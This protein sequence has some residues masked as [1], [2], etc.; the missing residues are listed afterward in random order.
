MVKKTRLDPNI[1]D[2]FKKASYEARLTPLF[3]GADA[4]VLKILRQAKKAHLIDGFKKIRSKET[5]LNPKSLY[6]IQAVHKDFR[7][8]HTLKGGVRTAPKSLTDYHMSVSLNS[9]NSVTIKFTTSQ[10]AWAAKKLSGFER[11]TAALNV[12]ENDDLETTSPQTAK[13]IK[14]IASFLSHHS[15][16]LNNKV[17]RQ[18]SS[19]EGGQVEVLAEEPPKPVDPPDVPHPRRPWIHRLWQRVKDGPQ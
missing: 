14:D 1:T 3:L 5:P 19:Q 4:L 16:I 9:D 10:F 2:I 13:F 12:V 7:Y 18:K 6:Y 15:M 17:Q 11:G 8:K